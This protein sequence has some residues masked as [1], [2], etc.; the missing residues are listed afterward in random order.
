MPLIGCVEHRHFQGPRLELKWRF[1]MVLNKERR[2]VQGTTHMVQLL[3]YLLS[4]KGTSFRHWRF[5]QILVTDQRN[6]L[7]SYP[8]PLMS[9]ETQ[10]GVLMNRLQDG[11]CI[12]QIG[13]QAAKSRWRTDKGKIREELGRRKMGRE[14]R[15]IFL[16]FLFYSCPSLW[17]CLCL[18][19]L[20]LYPLLCPP[21]IY[22][23]CILNYTS[24]LCSYSLAVLYHETVLHL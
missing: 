6:S 4:M 1:L 14:W 5:K 24:R 15:P 11:W 23:R 7:C 22:S 2:L 8:V 21:L 3:A 13:P 12:Y 19:L 16:C 17:V 18:S 10:E 9:C 20:V